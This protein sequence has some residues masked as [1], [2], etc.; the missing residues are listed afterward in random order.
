M[1]LKENKWKQ[2][3][4]VKNIFLQIYH[5]ICTSTYYNVIWFLNLK[6]TDSWEILWTI[7]LAIKIC[8][9]GEYISVEIYTGELSSVL[10]FF[11][12]HFHFS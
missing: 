4:H 5:I 1:W 11:L 2:I 9:L 7:S 8:I 3:F 6:F 10:F 12:F